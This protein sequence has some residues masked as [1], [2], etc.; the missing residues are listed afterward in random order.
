LLID[1]S[2]KLESFLESVQPGEGLSA[3]RAAQCRA[4]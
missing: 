1:D 3:E 2:R 4:L